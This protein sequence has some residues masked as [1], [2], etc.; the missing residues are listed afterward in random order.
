MPSVTTRAVR[1]EN[2]SPGRPQLVLWIRLGIK[3]ARV[4]EPVEPATPAREQGCRGV[5]NLLSYSG[6]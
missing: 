6:S 5:D 1:R 4:M 2:S 3:R